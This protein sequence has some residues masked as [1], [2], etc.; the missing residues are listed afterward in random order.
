MSLS[1]IEIGAR[2][3]V[4]IISYVACR[5]VGDV[6]ERHFRQNM[7]YLDPNGSDMEYS[8]WWWERWR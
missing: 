5:Y 6:A 8:R 1:I 7:T 4:P 2:V 3:T